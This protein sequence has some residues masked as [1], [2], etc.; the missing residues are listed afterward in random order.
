MV[1]THHYPVDTFKIICKHR[2]HQDKKMHKGNF[3]ELSAAEEKTGKLIVNAAYVVHKALGP[4]LLEKVYEV[5][6]CHVLTKFKCTLINRLITIL[7][8]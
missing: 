3:I 5:C 7:R 8:H 4:G 6:F 2:S 1:N